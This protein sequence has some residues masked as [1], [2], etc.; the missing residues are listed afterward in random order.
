MY[1]RALRIAPQSA[2][3]WLSAGLLANDSGDQSLSLE[4]LEEAVRIGPSLFPAVEAARRI[5]VG[6]GLIDRAVRFSDQACKLRP[7]DDIRIA[8]S[9]TIAAIQPSVDAVKRSRE[10]Y[11]DGLDAAIAANLRVDDMYAAHGMGA[12]FLA[13]HA[14]TTVDCRSRRPSF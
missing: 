14:K 13:Y 8:L 7:A 12:F 11:E 2:G 5:C 1:R 4:Y 6:V 3:L 9:L 10:A